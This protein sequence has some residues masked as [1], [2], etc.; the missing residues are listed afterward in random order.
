[1]AN[2]VRKRSVT[3]PPSLLTRLARLLWQEFVPPP[4]YR[5]ISIASE[6]EDAILLDAD[7]YRLMASR[8]TGVVRMA[9]DTVSLI[10]DIAAIEVVRNAASEHRG[11]GYELRLRT[12]TGHFISYCIALDEV[13]VA[14][15][16]AHLAK[17]CGKDVVSDYSR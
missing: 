4:L 9:Q 13:G 1:M 16:A 3:R 10:R 17:V 7:G 5:T 11:P 15:A 14:I 6:T 8:A 2:H 12:T